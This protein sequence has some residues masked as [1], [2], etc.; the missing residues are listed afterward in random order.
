MEARGG[1]GQDSIETPFRNLI[2]D[3]YALDATFSRPV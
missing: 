3:S 1:N 2:G